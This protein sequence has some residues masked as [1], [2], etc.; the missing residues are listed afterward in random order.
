MENQ[1]TEEQ[2]EMCEKWEKSRSRGKVAGGIL[3]VVIGS[4]FLGRE[5]GAEIPAWVFTWK[6]LLIGIGIVSAIKHNFRH[7]AWIILIGIGSAFL[8]NDFYPEMHLKPILIPILIIIAGL[9]IIFKPRRNY[10]KWGR[11][12][13]YDRYYRNHGSIEKGFDSDENVINCSTVFGAVKKNIISKEFKGG[14]VSLVCGGLEL[15][16]TN[17]EIVDQA[18]LNVSIVMGGIKLVI[19]AHWSI[20]SEVSVTMG[21]VEDKRRLQPNTTGTPSKVLLLKGEVVMGGIEIKSY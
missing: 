11:W 18:T 7:V 10:K 14:E 20:K 3:I 13:R 4:L 2:K 15:D 6:M 19:P 8:I 12:N 1:I 9:F 16:L 17:A 21:D 5:L